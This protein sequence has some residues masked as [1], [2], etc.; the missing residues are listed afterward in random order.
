MDGDHLG[1]CPAGGPEPE[2]DDRSA[3]D[4]GVV[5]DDEAHLGLADRRERCPERIEGRVEIVRHQRRVGLEAP[6]HETRHHVGLLE[7][8]GAREGDDDRA[9]RRT[10]ALLGDVERALEGDRR[11]S[12]GA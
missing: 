11:Q 2:V 4:D 8:L 12:L 1:A 7:R 9:P 3:L 6:A 10:Q 5:P